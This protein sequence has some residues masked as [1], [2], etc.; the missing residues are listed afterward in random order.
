MDTGLLLAL[1]ASVSFAVGI[2]LARK[3]AN[4]AG[5]AFTVTSLS[6]LSGIPLFAI[7]LSISGEWSNLT[8]I[9]AKP[10]LALMAVGIIHFIIG[11]MLAYDAFRF[12]GAN[13]G[14]PITQISQIITVILSWIFLAERPTIFVGFGALCMLAGVFLISQEKSKPYGEEKKRTSNEV[15]GILLCLVAA[16]CWG[17]T[18]I[19]IKPAVAEA[20]STVVGNFISYTTAG[21]II[22]VMLLLSKTRR[23]HFKKLSLKTQ[24]LPMVMSGLFTAAGQLLFFAALGR[25]PANTVAPLVSI[26]VLFIYVLSF[27]VN[28]KIEVFTLKVVLG[29]AAMVAGTF[30]LFR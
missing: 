12:I 1:I 22:V 29:M 6:I 20:G 8:G 13:R 10:L 2:V 11:R 21:I 23:E 30:L 15:K 5:E 25:S 28:R 24:A 3:T 19:L 9:A 26:E 18:P 7:A 27:V 16:L 14:T 4:E 17:I